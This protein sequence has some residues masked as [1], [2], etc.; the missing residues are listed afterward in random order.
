MVDASIVVASISAASAVVASA[1]SFYF[2]KKKDREVD[3]RKNKF[4][5]YREFLEAL[6]SIAGSDSTPDGNRR[7]ALACNTLHLIASIEVVRALHDFQ[8]EI[9]V[10]NTE[11]S[12]HVHD[13]LLSR[14]VWEI[15]KDLGIP[16]TANASEFSMYL[17]TSGASDGADDVERSGGQ[18]SRSDRTAAW[19]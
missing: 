6:G 10:S 13:A 8:D 2:S 16:P 19:P 15:R 14:L 3:W 9:R 11:K 1:L 18:G 5:Y 17:W 4:E 12:R 7:F